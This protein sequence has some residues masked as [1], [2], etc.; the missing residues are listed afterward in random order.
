MEPNKQCGRCFQTT[1]RPRDDRRTTRGSAIVRTV[2]VLRRR[3]D[4][5]RHVASVLIGAFFPLTYIFALELLYPHDTGGVSAGVLSI[6]NNLGC[7]A[8]LA[9]MAACSKA[10]VSNI[11]MAAATVMALILT[12]VAREG[13]DDDVT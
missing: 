11:T 2:V 4:R 12:A 10:G 5:N 3:A 1:L 7:L 9:A 8:L 6:L 13:K